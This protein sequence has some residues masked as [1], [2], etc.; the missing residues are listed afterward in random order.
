[1]KRRSLH[2]RSVAAPILFVVLFLLAFQ[3]GCGN[4]DYQKPIKQFQDAS[5]VVVASARQSLVQMNNVEETAELY[6]QAF[7]AE[8]FSEKK[9]KA[10]DLITQEQIN[11]RVNALDQLSRYSQA[12][13]DLVVLKAPGD[14]TKQFQD[15]G[16][17]FTTLAQDADKLSGA[18]SALFD[19]PKFSGAAKAVT[20]GIG[21]VVRAVEERRARREIEKQIREND[22]AVTDLIQMIGDDLRLAYERRRQSESEEGVFLTGA[23]KL[24]IEKVDHGDPALRLLLGDRLRDWRSRQAALAGADPKPSVEAMRKAHAALV[25]YVN[26]DKSSKSL[27]ELYAAAQDFFS[28]V[29]PLGQA[30]AALL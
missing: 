17:A 22:A 21:T 27:S 25:A 8:P 6:R 4:E 11:L 16:S 28:R 3:V 29:Q 20:I 1:M 7:E 15:V 9:I 13:A 23:L 10:R 5:A 14:V 18:P 24:E 12:L 2:A 19:N 26:S 30:M